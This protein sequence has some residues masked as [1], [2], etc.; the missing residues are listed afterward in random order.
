MTS[1]TKLSNASIAGE[2]VARSYLTHAGEVRIHSLLLIIAF[3]CVHFSGELKPGLNVIMGPTG[4]GKT[5][6]TYVAT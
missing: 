2:S 3:L 6:L 1:H 5:R 4:S